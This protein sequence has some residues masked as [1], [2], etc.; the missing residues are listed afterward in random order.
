MLMTKGIL[1]IYGLGGKTDK[2]KERKTGN[3]KDRRRK[4]RKG[5]VGSRNFF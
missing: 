5:K 2:G 3:K 4:R 1:V